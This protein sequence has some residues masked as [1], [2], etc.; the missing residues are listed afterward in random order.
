MN[1]SFRILTQGVSF[2]RPKNDGTADLSPPKRDEVAKKP[3]SGGNQLSRGKSTRGNLDNI[4]G[5]RVNKSKKDQAKEEYPEQS[6]L[7]EGVPADIS[8]QCNAS[9]S[10]QMEQDRQDD[11]ADES[12]SEDDQ[13]AKLQLFSGAEPST[14]F[15]PAKRKRK[16]K[17]KKDADKLALIKQ[18][19]INHFRNL[20]NIHVTGEDIPEPVETFEEL[21]TRFQLN[22][23]LVENITKIGYQQPTP[24]QMQAIPLVLQGRNILASAPT[25]SGK[26]AAFLIPIIQSLKCFNNFGYRAVVVSPTR[27]LAKQ[28]FFET[29]RLTLGTG[30]R[31]HLLEDVPKFVKR[32]K[33]N[34][35][36]RFDIL[37][38]TPNRLV[39]LLSKKPAVVS[40][41]S[42]E[43]LVIDESDKLFEADKEGGF[44]DQLA[45]IYK[46][47]SSPK[48]RRLLFSA[49][50]AIEVEEWCKQH[51][52]NLAEVSIG[53]RNAATSAIDQRLVFVGTED[54]KTSALRKIL[55]EEYT[56]P[57]LIFVESK[58]RAKE[59][60]RELENDRFHV[61]VIHSDREQSERDLVVSSF[62]A[63]NIWTLIATEVLGRGID[64]KGVNMVINYDF[65]LTSISYIHRIGRTGRAGQR[66]KAITFFTEADDVNLRSIASVMQRSG[67]EVPAFM[68]QLPK[69]SSSVR[70]QL[71][72]NPKELRKKLKNRVKMKKL[73]KG[74]RKAK[75]DTRFSATAKP[76]A[77]TKTDS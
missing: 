5:S 68:L 16:K 71:K 29:D 50:F 8:A 61:D 33:K 26:T 22:A 53:A 30:L 28:T 10:T 37:V 23:R 24:I 41:E 59:L 56:P 76:K 63:G 43:W 18:E 35:S 36:S 40:L 12:S 74:I 17:V 62:R 49:T 20:H 72:R 19:K 47:C 45:V 42:V 9:L 31:T 77:A 44:R 27:E 2:K 21:A 54:G 34:R 25:G 39:F 66:G 1:A 38:T 69:P 4:F 70:K 7:E 14:D 73:G 48:V 60:F 65:P 64:F 67:C 6:D 46:A 13:P 52:D 32:A 51:L 55:Q 58:Q 3:P 57:V 75:A 15:T 11:E